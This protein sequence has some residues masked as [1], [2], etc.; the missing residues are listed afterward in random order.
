MDAQECPDGEW[1]PTIY[2]AIPKELEGTL[3]RNGP[4]KFTLGGKRIPHP[5]DGDGF[6]AS[7]ALKD[8]NAFY[9]SKFVNTP[10]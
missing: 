4:G 9:R 5:Y 6:V 2:G 3:F 1:L 8:G 10:E 7:V